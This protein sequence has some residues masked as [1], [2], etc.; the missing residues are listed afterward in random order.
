MIDILQARIEALETHIAHQ[1]QTVDDLNSVI[2]AQREELDRLTRRV[3]K[4]L[5]R[6]EDLEAAAPGP[7]VTKPPHY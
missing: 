6:L 2:L 1:D 4:M 7:E 5:A 3:N